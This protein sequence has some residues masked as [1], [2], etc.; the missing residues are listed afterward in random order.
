[1]SVSFEY[2]AASGMVSDL[3]KQAARK[4][5]TALDHASLTLCPLGIFSYFLSSADFVQNQLFSKKSFRNTF[6]VS[7]SLNPDQ[8]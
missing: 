3:Q 2:H 4:K 1:M 6:G 5:N 8:A 7:N